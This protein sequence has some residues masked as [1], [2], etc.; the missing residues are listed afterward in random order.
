MKEGIK[1]KRFGQLWNIWQQKCFKRDEDIMNN[2]CEG[3][4][5][6]HLLYLSLTSNWRWIDYCGLRRADKP[7][8]VPPVPLSIYS[9]SSSFISP[10]Y[11]GQVTIFPIYTLELIEP[12]SF[13]IH[14]IFVI[15]FASLQILFRLQRILKNIFQRRHFITVLETSSF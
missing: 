4:D 3:L 2:V 14:V 1:K 6:D 7:S 11:L 13:L 12:V 15:F 8:L 9:F 10:L 5:L